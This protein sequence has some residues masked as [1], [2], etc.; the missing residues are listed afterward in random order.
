VTGGIECG[1]HVLDQLWVDTGRTVGRSIKGS[2]GVETGFL[3][4]CR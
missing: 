4:A 1:A 3:E 2:K